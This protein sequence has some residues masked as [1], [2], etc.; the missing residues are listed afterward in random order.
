MIKYFRRRTPPAPLSESPDNA[1]NNLIPEPIISTK[2]YPLAILLLTQKK[3]SE[4]SIKA[5]VCS[6]HILLISHYL[7][8]Y[9]CETRSKG[10]STGLQILPCHSHLQLV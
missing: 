2:Q 5:L 9:L 6:V 10:G 3:A 4:S 7:S 1:H 8:K